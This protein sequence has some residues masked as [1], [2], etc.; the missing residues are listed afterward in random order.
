MK[1]PTVNLACGRCGSI[2][3]EGGYGALTEDGIF[4]IHCKCGFV[5]KF[6]TKGRR[7]TSGRKWIE[8]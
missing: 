3:A 5:T 2:S 1:A 7:H 4:E 6:N 8:R